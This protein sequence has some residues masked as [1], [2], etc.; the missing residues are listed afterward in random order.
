MISPTDNKDPV[1]HAAGDM[2]DIEVR[3]RWNVHI[4]PKFQNLCYVV[5]KNNNKR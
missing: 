2:S 1:A 5:P 3:Q 4:C